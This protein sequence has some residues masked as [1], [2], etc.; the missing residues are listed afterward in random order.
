MGKG[1]VQVYYGTGKGKTTAALGQAIRAASQ[2][3]SVIIIQFLKARNQEAISFISRLEP[4]I[5]LF[6]FEKFEGYFD[7]LSAEEKAEEIQNI[8]NGLNFAKKVLVTEE[9]QVLV[10]D[11]ILGL[12]DHQIITYDDIK[13]LFDARREE[14]ELILTGTNFCDD[15]KK[16]AD[17]IYRIETVKSVDN[18]MKE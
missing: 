4:E 16:D 14:T 7:Q 2:G 15:I 8:K 13:V 11:E 12:F 18:G 1:F 3:K 5:K 17:N 6:R 9:C 10:L